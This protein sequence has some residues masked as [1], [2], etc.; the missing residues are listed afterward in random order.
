MIKVIFCLLISVSAIAQKDVKVDSTQIFMKEV[1]DTL[2]LK[3]FN[4]WLMDNI[5]ARKYGEFQQLY[6]AFLQQKYEAW[7]RRKKE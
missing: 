6:S 5:S 2:R 7:L 1:A 3:D 4:E